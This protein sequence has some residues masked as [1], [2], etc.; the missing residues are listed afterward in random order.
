MIIMFDFDLF[1]SNLSDLNVILWFIVEGIE[2]RYCNRF[3]VKLI[4]GK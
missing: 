1:I 4:V 3:Y 2:V